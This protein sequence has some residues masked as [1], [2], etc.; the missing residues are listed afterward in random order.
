MARIQYPFND[1]Y[2]RISLSAAYALFLCI[3]KAFLS[4]YI[5]LH[6]SEALINFCLYTLLCFLLMELILR[7]TLHL[8]KVSDWRSRPFTRTFSQLFLGLACPLLLEL[9]LAKL[10]RAYFPNILLDKGG[11]SYPQISIF[12]LLVNLYYTCL[13]LIGLK[14]SNQ[15]S[16]RKARNI[17]VVHSG[18]KNIPLQQSKISHILRVG[19]LVQVITLDQEK[20]TCNY[21]LDELEE[22]LGNQDF[23]RANRQTIVNYYA[24]RHFEPAEYGKLKLELI[25]KSPQPITISQKRVKT[26]RKW[27]N[28]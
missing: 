14:T 6:Y 9:Y 19:E 17:L 16:E 18:H 10:V 21:S 26:F 22:L 27:I 5:G 1:V 7:V 24:C 13:Y 11:F 15:L 23:F 12:V 4:G 8:D 3:Q 28:Q 20:Y 2:F 25:P